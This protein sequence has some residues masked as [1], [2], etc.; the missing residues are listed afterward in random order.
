MCDPTV[1]LESTIHLS[2]L[3]PDVEKTMKCN[4]KYLFVCER[5]HKVRVFSKQ[6]DSMGKYLF[7]LDEN[8]MGSVVDNRRLFVDTNSK[9]SSQMQGGVGVGGVGG[10]DFYKSSYFSN[11][12]QDLDVDKR[13][14]YVYVVYEYAIRVHDENCELVWEFDMGAR[15]DLSGKLNKVCFTPNGTMALV[16]EDH[17]N[18]F[19]N[20]VYLFN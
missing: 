10:R 9:R 3:K 14:G 8:G 5:A 16:L 20:R 12:L 11:R 7:S 19:S 4:Q 2:I 6:P 1:S 15:S 17:K 13:N 18:E